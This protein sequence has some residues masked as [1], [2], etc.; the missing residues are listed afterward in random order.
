LKQPPNIHLIG[1]GAI[2]CAYAKQAK[3]HGLDI[4]IMCDSER[5]ERYLSHPFMI[6]GEQSKFHYL[7]RKSSNKIDLILICVKTYQ[8]QSTIP[9]IRRFLD[10]DTIVISLLNGISSEEILE[11]E[12]GH[13]NII[14]AY[15][16][17][18]DAKKYG[19]KVEFTNKGKI[20][21]G[22]P[23][24]ER[25]PILNR[26]IEI[27][28]H[29]GFKIEV[30]KDIRKALWWKLMLNIGINHIAALFKIGY[31]KF[32]NLHIQKLTKAAMMEAVHVANAEGVNLTKQDAEQIFE[33][34][35]QW[36]KDS[37]ASMLQDV[38]NGRKTE[39]EAFSGEIIKRAAQHGLEVPI[40][41]F[42]FH[43]IKFLEGKGVAS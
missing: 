30:S 10:H 41:E 42:L 13:T 28:S 20:V 1:L 4:S 7:D 14:H 15:T 27:F 38:E 29:T 17:G 35:K 12:L 37:K 21:I 6:N 26:A 24:A 5:K 9:T 8:L 34:S 39:V 32:Q 31:G 33:A 40:N 43:A 36:G 18:T 19:Q 25:Q 16:V 3:D 2:G 23:Y 11:K 22:T